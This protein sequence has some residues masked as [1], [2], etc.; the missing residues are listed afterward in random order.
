ALGKPVT[1]VNHIEAHLHAGTLEHGESPWP[2]L[3]LVVSG[4][5]TELVDVRG[6]GRYHW[7]GSTLD[8]AVGGAYGKVAKRMGLGFAGGPVSDRLAAQGRRE[9]FDFPRP[10]LA[11]DFDFSFSGL[12]TAVAVAV[13]EHG[14][15]PYPPELVADLA[16]SFQAAAIDVLVAK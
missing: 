12:K 8:D 1:G 6:R 3:A 9:A 7:L 10:M 11:R 2:A 13:A 5:H 15:P 14:E 16:A 4:G